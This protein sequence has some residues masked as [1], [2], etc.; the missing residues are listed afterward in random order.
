MAISVLLISACD[1]YN[2]LYI[3]QAGE[4]EEVS[5]E[6]IIVEGLDEGAMEEAE[7]GGEEIDAGIAE[8]EEEIPEDATVLIVKETELVNLVP[9]AED[10]DKDALIFTF[11]SPLD[12]NGQ[13]QTTYGDA[14]E[15]TITVTASDEIGR[16]SC[17]E[18][19]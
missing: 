5:D 14:G 3:K 8:E 6:E 18:R 19:V 17:R 16:A 12:D 15:Y 2:T 1:V 7:A 13:W 10:P 4:A 9:N 11:T